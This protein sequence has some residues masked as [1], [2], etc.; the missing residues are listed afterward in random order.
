MLRSLKKPLVTPAL[1]KLCWDVYIGSSIKETVC[2]LCGLY[3]IYQST[4]SGY[5]ACHVVARKFNSD[6]LS[7]YYIT[8]G[9]AACNNICADICILDY[10]FCRQRIG[11]LRKF[12][13][14][15]YTKF[16]EEHEHS[17]AMEDRM[18]WHVLDYLYGMRRFPA[19]GGIVNLKQ[20]YEIARSEQM[21]LLTNEMCKIGARLQALSKEY[22]MVTECEIKPMRI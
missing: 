13:Q 7:I 21:V 5:E 9:C 20:I 4:N 14:I 16:V 15:V 8:V 12:M 18:I 1:K 2:P 11:A 19:G 6:A 3:Q 22:A 17:L 10:L